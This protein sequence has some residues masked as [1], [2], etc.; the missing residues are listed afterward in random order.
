MKLKLTKLMAIIVI[1]AGGVLTSNAQEFGVRFGGINGSGGIGVDAAFGLGQYSRIHSDLGIYK[2][3]L[4]LNALWDFVNRPL[5]DE[6]LNWYLGIGPSMYIGNN[7]WLG[8]SGEIGL[9]YRFL[10]VPI[11]FG[12]DWRPTYWLAN[13]KR[14]GADSFGINIRFII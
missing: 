10:S 13:N 9:E 12:I 11:A 4:G 1:L 8:I 7:S 14:F 5:S 3:G 6:A 2:N